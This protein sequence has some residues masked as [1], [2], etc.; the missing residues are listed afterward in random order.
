MN[1]CKTTAFLTLFLAENRNLE[2]KVKKI[3]RILCYLEDMQKAL[4]LIKGFLDY[5]VSGFDCV[6]EIKLL[7]IIVAL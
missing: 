3:T 4:A 6:L 2:K 7:T 1:S 5:V